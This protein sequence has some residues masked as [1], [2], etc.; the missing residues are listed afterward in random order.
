MTRRIAWPL[1]FTL[2][3]ALTFL[4]SAASAQAATLC[5]FVAPTATVTIDP[6]ASATLTRSGTAIQL[7]G[8]NCGAATVS[9]TD[10]IIVT[11]S[12]GSET[13]TLDLSGGPFVPGASTEGT[14]AAEIEL[15]LGLAGQPVFGPDKLVVL[16]TGNGDT[17]RLGS[18]GVNLN[19]DD[20]ADITGS[21]GGALVNTNT[22][23]FSVL[24]AGGNDTISGQG[25]VNGVV[26]P[27]P[28]PLALDLQGGN[29]DDTLTGGNYAD[30][31]TGGP[32][33]DIEAGGLNTDTFVEDAV[34]NGNDN[35]SGGPGI[36]DKLDYG[37]RTAGLT[38]SLD[39]L[40]NDGQP[41]M[42]LD[43][44]QTDVESFVLGSGNDTFTG[45]GGAQI[46]VSAGAGTDTITGGTGS[47]AL[48]GGPNNDTI[49][50]GLGNDLIYGGMG[51]DDLFGDA[52]FDHFY[53][54]ADDG[55][56]AVTTANGADEMTGGTEADAVV[57]ANRGPGMYAVTLDNA[58]NDGLDSIVGGAAEEGDNVHD[59]VED[60][61]GDA[62]G[63]NRITGSSAPNVIQGGTGNDTISSLGGNDT[64]G[65]SYGNDTIDGGSENDLL[66]GFYGDDT[67]LGQAGNDSLFGQGDNDTLTGGPDND[68][69]VGEVGNDTVIED[70][71]SANGA[72]SLSAG[73][74]T[75]TLSYKSRTIGVVVDLDGVAADDGQDTNADGVADELDTV[76]A[77]FENRVGGSGNDKRTAQRL[78]TA[79]ANM[80]TGTGGAD[81][82]SA[83]DGDDLLD[84]G[85]GGDTLNGGAGV[86]T[87]TYAA[88]T[89]RLRVDI[90]GTLDGT[91][92]D[93][94][95][96][97]EE[98]DTTAGDIENLIGGEGP[99]T[100]IGSGSDNK[101]T[102]NGNQDVMQGLNGIDTLDGGAGTD[103][104]VG[105]PANDIEHG[106]FS[107]DTFD[108]G[109]SPDGQDSLFGEDGIDTVD[110][111]ARAASVAVRID[112][113]AN[114]GADTNHDGFGLEE[115]D[116]VR[117]D[118]EN[119][120]GGSE[121]DTLVGGDLANR[122]VGNSGDDLLD[123][124]YGADTMDGGIGVD[125][126][127]YDQRIPPV[128]VTPD[129]MN[130]NDG[131]A[132]EGDNVLSTVE[133]L[134]GGQGGDSLY[135]NA[136][137]NL[138][139][140][141]DGADLLDG[142][143]GPDVMQGGSG[144][145]L[146]DY[147]SRTTRTQVTLD[148]V[149][150][151]GRNDNLDSISDENDN[152]KSD[153]ENVT[154]GSLPDELTGDADKNE[155]RGQ[156]GDDFLDGQTGDDKLVGGDGN[157]D[158]L[159]GLGKDQIFGEAGDDFVLEGPAAAP[160]G[161]DDISGGAGSHDE[162]DYFG[163]TNP[164]T[165]NIDNLANDGD[166]GTSEGDNIRP[167]VE[168]ADGGSGADSI[169]GSSSANRLFGGPGNDVI[170]GNAAND[171]LS[172]S[173]GNDVLAGD[174]GNDSLNGGV[175]N[176]TE[177][178]GAGSDVMPEESGANG[179]DTFTDS[180]QDATVD[181]SARTAN[182]VIDV[183]GVADD[184]VPGEKDNVTQSIYRVRGGKGMDRLTAGRANG[185]LLF[186]GPG[187]DFLQGVNGD[188]LYGDAGPDTLN[189]GPQHDK[190]IGGPGPDL[191]LGNGGDD[192][193]WQD[194]ECSFPCPPN[195]SDE[196]HGGA[197]VD[198]VEY[199]GRV[200]PVTVTIDDIADDGAA[201]EADNVFTDIEDLRG[202]HGNDTLTGSVF[203][204]R[205][206]GCYGSDTVNGGLGD[207]T[208]GG[209]SE[210]IGISGSD[211]IHGDGGDDVIY[212][213]SEL[214]NTDDQ[215]DQ[216]FGDDGADM[217]TGGGGADQM[218]GGAGKDQFL[219]LDGFVDTVDGGPDT[220]NGIF[221]PGD[222][223]TSIP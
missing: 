43:N 3:A 162:V 118:I 23:L 42:E 85:L 178:G 117:T 30:T 184:G 114:D 180:D 45:G 88:R 172:G 63:T 183:D 169:I 214:Q 171:V 125:T 59:D 147:G 112:G 157:D 200:D 52:G 179:A 49:H 138:L 131:E 123:G 62:G 139:E 103:K 75:D 92:A 68:I 108:Q 163:R 26:S 36:D 35:F 95:G 141:N 156:G 145:D 144:I 132:A 185:N 86:D 191:E 7:N 161:A 208:L 186:G 13:L 22:E 53:E 182:L 152:V 105:G 177:E 100:L 207:D 46:R 212:G 174:A 150:N 55:V 159:G 82:L 17:Y 14:G 39:G 205:I 67:L 12:T 206:D 51:D 78:G 164:V 33:T 223:K 81:V 176:D 73:P 155:L 187:L 109:A 20:D 71:T 218:N 202:G 220:D 154:G 31:I 102:G 165:I 137:A 56:P 76:S 80:R 213:D 120:R 61:T 153:V 111:T 199:T 64:V 72:D 119:V 133:N 116:N 158:A 142:L 34:A 168:D 146:A 58:Q 197:G 38:V 219:A 90:G 181:Y 27:V 6:G 173:T 122:L 8:I 115:Q 211:T 32:G 129:G 28:S 126:A 15:E 79:V 210:C 10:K 194:G 124:G 40:A 70:G 134:R 107:N 217:I 190:L 204:N 216:L 192:W 189:G 16:G 60:V 151:D 1:L 4:F 54:D 77:D 41:G 106:G 167:D 5:G 128:V 9:N 143:G 97:A 89:T 193:F 215:P 149:A 48:Y 21:G 222:I 113:F 11:G 57:Y 84:G 198:R 135:G 98:G 96:M 170:S 101:L 69:V 127:N 24:G 50:G 94:N 203:A 175:G 18:T 91:D 195:G 93:N 47:E 110:Y 201:G 148:D 104:L 188:N 83:N 136:S 166:T 19:D 160:N 29:A 209:D 99:D 221:D 87:S 140:G 66:N 37:A 44:V 2:T 121:A 25:A 65:G 196:L 74:G 130:A